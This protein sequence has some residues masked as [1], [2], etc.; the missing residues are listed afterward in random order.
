M[1]NERREI[2]LSSSSNDCREATSRELKDLCDCYRS[3]NKY[4]AST[5]IKY[6]WLNVSC[7]DKALYEPKDQN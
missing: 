3:K 7:T 2:R 6:I 4:L 1:S 5:N